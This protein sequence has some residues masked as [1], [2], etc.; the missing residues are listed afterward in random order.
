M[1]CL[2]ENPNMFECW[3]MTSPEI[4]Q[5]VEEFTA[6]NANYDD[7]KLPHQEERCAP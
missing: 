5:V 1:V 3:I 7:E 4:S 6:S 2:T